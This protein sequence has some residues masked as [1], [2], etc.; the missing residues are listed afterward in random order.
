[1]WNHTGVDTNAGREGE[2][3]GEGDTTDGAGVGD[4]REAEEDEVEAVG[5]TNNTALE[6]KIRTEAMV[7]ERK[8]ERVG[9][10]GD[11]ADDED[12]VVA[13]K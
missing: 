10:G 5:S 4:D 6:P 8:G 7:P 2:D 11:G 13:A 12:A 1:M 3:S 9:K